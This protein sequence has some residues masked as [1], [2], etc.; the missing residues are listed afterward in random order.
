MPRLSKH[1]EVKS[2][3]RPPVVQPAPPA[4]GASA[5]AETEVT[6]PPASPS[7]DA[8]GLWGYQASSIK[9]NQFWRGRTTRGEKDAC[10]GLRVSE[11]LVHYRVQIPLSA[12]PPRRAPSLDPQT[13]SP[14]E[15][16]PTPSGHR[17]LRGEAY[18]GLARGALYG[19]IQAQ[20]H[21]KTIKL[22]LLKR[23]REAC[24]SLLPRSARPTG[25]LRSRP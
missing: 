7:P 4:E 21:K 22:P 17:Q 9:S 15:R 1:A 8:A 3:A 24:A 2:W 10:Q 13:R 6:S 18:A 16:A 11:E 25:T 5:S 20:L 23:A 12:R 14:A 19:D